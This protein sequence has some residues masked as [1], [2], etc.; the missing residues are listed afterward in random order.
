MTSELVSNLTGPEIFFHR[1]HRDGPVNVHAAPQF[2]CTLLKKKFKGFLGGISSVV[3]L[4]K[5]GLLLCFAGMQ[6]TST[7]INAIFLTP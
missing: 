7:W 4:K 6:K 1:Q 3:P 2:F 5:Q